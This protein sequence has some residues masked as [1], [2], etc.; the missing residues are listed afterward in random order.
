[1]EDDRAECCRKW[2]EYR[3]IDT[4]EIN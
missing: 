3:G 2:A 1:M 4:L